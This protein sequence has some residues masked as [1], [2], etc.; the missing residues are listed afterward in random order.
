MLRLFFNLLFFVLPIF[1][2]EPYLTDI[3]QLTSP[4]LGFT[5]A[6]EAYFSPDGKKILFQ[7]VPHG[8]EDYQIYS[9]D[10][11]TKEILWIS[12]GFASCTCAFFRPDGEKIIFAGS[13]L[14]AKK[15]APGTYAWDFTPYMNIYEANPDGSSLVPLTDGPAYH[16]ECAYSPDGKQIV[17]A[18]NL[19][20]S[21]NLYIMSEGT[22]IR[23]LTETQNCYNGG[24]FFS[25]DGKK[26]LFRSDRERPH[27]LQIYLLDLESGHLSQITDNEAVNWAPYWHPSGRA[28]AF[29][30]SLKGHHSYQIF[31]LDL[32]TQSLT[33]ITDTSCFNGLPVFN[34]NGTKLLWTSKRGPDQTSQVF[35]AQFQLPE[36]KDNP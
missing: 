19:D 14:K 27:Y 31:Y 30:S 2:D 4:D 8:E 36:N 21:M 11:A 32:I 18:S 3:Q 17:F 25:P 23:Q 35:L 33:Q 1:A 5:K 29:T 34:Y 10:L 13:H 7:A 22:E 12:K 15:A 24:P 9:M 6:G 26:V 20:G 16:A 28:I